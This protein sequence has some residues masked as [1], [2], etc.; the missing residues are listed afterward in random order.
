MSEQ[1]I[2]K[3]KKA[4]AGPEVIEAALEA[5]REVGKAFQEYQQT[6]REI[7]RIDANYKLLS[8]EIEARYSL[9]REIFTELFAERRAAIEK[10]FE[11]IDRG[12]QENNHEF[13]IHGLQTLGVV[14]ASSPFKDFGLLSQK[15]ESDKDVIEI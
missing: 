13:V 14:V 7:A 10:S 1:M 6:K 3:A 9:Y 5:L 12:M 4:G 8:R 2:N 15:L 11:V